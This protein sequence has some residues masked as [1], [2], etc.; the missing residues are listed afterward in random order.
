MGDN[1]SSFPLQR[2][3]V[4]PSMALFGRAQYNKTIKGNVY[5]RD[6]PEAVLVR[7]VS[8]MLSSELTTPT[9]QKEMN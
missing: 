8:F 3:V 4:R 6:F 5:S 2:L 9:T 7:D 1:E